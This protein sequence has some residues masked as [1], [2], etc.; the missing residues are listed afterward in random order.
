MLQSSFVAMAML[1]LECTLVQG[2]VVMIT[3]DII[4]AIVMCY[5]VVMVVVMHFDAIEIRLCCSGDVH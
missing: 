4:V 3:C 1:L 5:D 2:I